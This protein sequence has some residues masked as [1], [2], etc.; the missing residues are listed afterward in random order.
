MPALSSGLLLPPRRFQPAQPCPPQPAGRPRQDGRQGRARTAPG[1]GRGKGIGT[2]QG[3]SR[4]HRCS[5]DSTV[6]HRLPREGTRGKQQKGTRG[7]GTPTAEA[8]ASRAAPGSEGRAPKRHPFPLPPGRQSGTRFGVAMPSPAVR[9]W[10]GLAARPPAPRPHTHH[11]YQVLH[12]RM[13]SQSS[14][15]VR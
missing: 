9:V 11:L 4:G 2:S 8:A 15:R 6:C 1:S 10:A 5:G 3:H 7:T 12:T 14:L 13:H